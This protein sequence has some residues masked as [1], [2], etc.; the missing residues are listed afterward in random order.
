MSAAKANVLFYFP[1][2]LDGGEFKKGKLRVWKALGGS[3]C[4]FQQERSSFEISVYSNLCRCFTYS[5][6]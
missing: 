2:K 6:N 3:Y 4:L 5:K 1:A